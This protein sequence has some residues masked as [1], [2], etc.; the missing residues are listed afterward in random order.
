MSNLRP[1]G[2]G[3]RALGA[4]L[5]ALL[6][7]SVFAGASLAAAGLSAAQGL[8]TTTVAP[9]TITVPTPVTTVEA[10]VPAPPVPT[11]TATAEPPAVT[12]STPVTTAG[13]AVP[14]LTESA[15]LPAP[16]LP[17]TE[18]PPASPTA[19]N[20]PRR[21]TSPAKRSAPSAP[22]APARTATS[23]E[24]SPDPATAASASGASAP[25]ADRSASAPASSHRAQSTSAASRTAPAR[26]VPG[27]R[28]RPL[29]V[30]RDRRAVQ[31]S[32]VL[33]R[34]RRVTLLFY[35]PAPACV[36]AG[37]L[38][39]PGRPGA[40]LLRFDGRVRHHLLSP[41]AYKVT[42]RLA[43]AGPSVLDP[44]AIAVWVDE[45]G[46]RP[47]AHMPRLNCEAA[48][49]DRLS[50]S[51]PAAV[52]GVKGV[53]LVRDPPHAGKP[54]TLSSPQRPLPAVEE[55]PASSGVLGFAQS[56]GSVWPTMALGGSLIWAL[57]LLSLA[58]VE[59][60]YGAARF[61]L[62]RAL[63]AHRAEVGLL[64]AGFLGLAAMLYLMARLA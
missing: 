53:Q 23:S 17:A 34:A 46:A 44:P 31:L 47:L 6:A 45:R 28:A 61:R 27:L 48:S 9:P 8:P 56:A 58:S 15:P 20:P 21:T 39:G 32:F 5:F 40:N 64:G 37:R 50:L 33:E 3:G 51:L 43:G 63:D 16:P 13:V 57:L 42:P 60:G 2:R 7:I 14:D 22:S 11:V 55:P 49:R 4:P 19:A 18:A 35:G 25:V 12:V 62:V 59:W 26:I 1:R 29:P 54:P 52:A 38:A 41:G 24:A 30:V 10:S 36:V